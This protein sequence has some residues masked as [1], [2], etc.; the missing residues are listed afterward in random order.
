ML[1]LAQDYL[2]S[3]K[4]T[5]M[6]KL[7]VLFSAAVLLFAC[8]NEEK[9]VN[10]I[11][12]DI[13]PIDHQQAVQP[14]DVGDMDDIELDQGE[15]WEVEPEISEGIG[16]IAE[17]VSNYSTRTA[18]DYQELGAKIGEEKKKFEAGIS[19]DAVYASNLRIYLNS[20]EKKI[21]R[22]KE[23]GSTQEGEEVLRELEEQLELYSSY[24]L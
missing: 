20:L 18:A 4:Y 16:R 9:Q 6:K 5:L 24:F 15:P 12:E 17:L 1:Q 14:G 8:K 11:P 10:E 19:N 13:A 22:L 3:I 23:V 7:V 2:T 21:D